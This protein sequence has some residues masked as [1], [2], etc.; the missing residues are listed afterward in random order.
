M[1]AGSTIG[2]VCPLIITAIQA[3]TGSMYNGPAIVLAA[4]GVLTAAASAG[5]MRYY[6]AANRSPAAAAL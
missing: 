6:P 4:T 1:C 2:G 3:A 5:L